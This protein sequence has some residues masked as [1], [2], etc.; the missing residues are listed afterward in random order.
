[1]KKY[2]IIATAVMTFAAC[3]NKEDEMAEMNT[4]IPVQFSAAV[5]VTET[6]AVDQMWS[7]AD[8]I[9]IYMIKAGESFEA[10]NISEEAANICYIVDETTSNNGFK[11]DGVTIYYPMDDSEVDFYA[12]YPQGASAVQ[13]ETD[14][15]YTYALDV[16]DQANQEAL[17]F[18]FSNNVKSKKKTDKSA[19]LTFKHQLCKVILT[20]K[21]G[22]GVDE[23]DLTG[24]TVKVNSQ[25]TTATFDL[26]AG[27][28]KAD[29]ANSA[30]VTLF[31]QTDAYIYEAIL[32]PNTGTA[33]T[34][35]FNLN[36][37]HD[38]PFTWDMETA[39]EGGS[40]YTY[41]VKLNRTGV[42]VS[43][44]IEAWNQGDAGEVEAY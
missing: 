16:T 40:K 22:E 26:T 14:G 4:R 17:D 31:K 11:P 37:G 3:S 5:G 43:G 7:A 25:N 39:L 9:G 2:L 13:T 32:L 44:T 42:E 41:T 18:M 8:A 29:A 28:L 20:V 10:T 19:A 38:A 36:N 12:Y 23:D 33:R 21:P 6:R 34:F 27:T 35:E 30:D 24:L 1:M 15:S